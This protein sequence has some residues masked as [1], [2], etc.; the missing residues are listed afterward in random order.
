MY[1]LFISRFDLFLPK[2]HLWPTKRNRKINK[3]MKTIEDV[4]T[5]IIREKEHKF[6]SASEDGKTITKIF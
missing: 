5:A 3:Y 4:V 1:F 6:K 2:W